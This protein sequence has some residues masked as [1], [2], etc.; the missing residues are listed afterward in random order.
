MAIIPKD[1]ELKIKTLIDRGYTGNPDTGEVFT[2]RNKLATSRDSLGYHLASTYLNGKFISVRISY[3]LWYLKYG[4]VPEQLKYINGDRNDNRISN[5]QISKRKKNQ[6]INYSIEIDIGNKKLLKEI[7]FN[8]NRVPGFNRILDKHIKNTITNE[9]YI[10]VISMIGNG[11]ISNVFEEVK[12]Y[13]FILC[14]N[15]VYLTINPKKSDIKI[16]R[17]YEDLSTLDIR[18]ED[19]YDENEVFF[20]KVLNHLLNKNY[21]WYQIIS[22]KLEKKNNKEI[23]DELGTPLWNIETERRKV[24]KYIRDN[25]D[26]FR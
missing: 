7:K 8:L 20:N 25:V 2:T 24:Y 19:Y 22:L 14:K 1:V 18:Q 9:A 15:E 10:K 23:Q 17:N 4:T 11:S 13:I 5:L 12:G 21:L 6:E 26:K 3:F 16:N